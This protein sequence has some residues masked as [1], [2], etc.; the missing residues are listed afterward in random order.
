MIWPNASHSSLGIAGLTTLLV[1]VIVGRTTG[2]LK[3]SN[4]SDLPESFNLS[5]LMANK[6]GSVAVIMLAMIAVAHQRIEP[7]ILLAGCVTWLI[8]VGSGILF[9][10]N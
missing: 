1:F 8:A 4:S 2:L 5:S 6:T 3:K 7:Y 9:R 10:Q